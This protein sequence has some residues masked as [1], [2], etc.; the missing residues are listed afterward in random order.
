MFHCFKKR[1]KVINF[2]RFNLKDK[3]FNKSIHPVILR[4]FRFVILL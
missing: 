2:V 3:H 1:F 4:K